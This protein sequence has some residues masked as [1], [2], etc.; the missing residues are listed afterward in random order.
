MIIPNA[1]LILTI[2]Y[3]VRCNIFI[4]HIASLH[5]SV[6]ILYPYRH[7]RITGSRDK[8]RDHVKFA[9]YH[10]SIAYLLVYLIL[11]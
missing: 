3:W 11:P 6:C 4:L 10:D 2:S 1:R 9:I 7:I 5:Y 8:D